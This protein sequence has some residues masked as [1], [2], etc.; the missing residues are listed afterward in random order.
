[1]S[2]EDGIDRI[3]RVLGLPPVGGKPIT[4]DVSFE[5]GLLALMKAH[6][7]PMV[8]MCVVQRVG[9]GIQVKALCEY[10]RDDGLCPQFNQ[11]AF[12]QG[13]LRPFME[14]FQRFLLNGKAVEVVESERKVL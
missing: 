6:N 7:V 2:S 13:F 14:A 12:N 9:G 5:D 10:N 11:L 4:I 8:A 1:M 3:A